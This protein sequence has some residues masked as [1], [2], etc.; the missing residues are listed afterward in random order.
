[1]GHLDS[2]P[3]AGALSLSLIKEEAGERFQFDQVA[4]CW[5]LSE[6]LVKLR[7]WRWSCCMFKH[8]LAAIRYLLE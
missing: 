2:Q 7:F 5:E 3:V 4:E 8:L 6:L 1:M